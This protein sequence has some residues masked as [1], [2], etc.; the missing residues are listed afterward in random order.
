[1]REGRTLDAATRGPRCRGWSSEAPYVQ[2]RDHRHRRRDRRR[3]RAAA[4]GGQ[5][6]RG[7]CGGAGRGGRRFAGGE[8]RGSATGSIGGAVRVRLRERRGGRTTTSARGQRCARAASLGHVDALREL[9]HCPQEGYGMRC[10]VLDGHRLLIQ[11][12]TRELAA[13]VTAS[14]SLLRATDKLA[15]SRA[16]LVPPLRLRLPHR[17][18]G[19]QL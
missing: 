15:A 5:C 12:N 17:G 3:L 6:V 7:H 2:R 19:T 18:Q 9:G 16:A 14:A 10:F 8:E 11:G 13:T 1:G 4:R